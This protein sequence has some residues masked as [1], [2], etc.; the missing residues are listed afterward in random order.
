MEMTRRAVVA[1]GSVLMDLG[2]LKHV[3]KIRKC[4]PV[5]QT[6]GHVNV[7]EPLR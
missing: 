3:S 6:G 1:A 2:K 5:P 4:Q 7:D